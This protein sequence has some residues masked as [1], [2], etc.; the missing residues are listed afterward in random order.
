MQLLYMIA[1][2]TAPVPAGASLTAA[3][4]SKHAQ[5]HMGPL[6]ADAC[7]HAWNQYC[8]QYGCSR[9]GVDCT[10]Q[11]AHDNTPAW[12]T[13][14]HQD[15]RTRLT[16]CTFTFT[17]TSRT[18]R[19]KAATPVLAARAEQ[20][21]QSPLRAQSSELSEPQLAPG[22]SPCTLSLVQRLLQESEACPGQLVLST[23]LQEECISRQASKRLLPQNAA[24]APHQYY[25]SCLCC[26]L[27]MAHPY[28]A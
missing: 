7:M 3:T 5:G 24:S 2:W 8:R 4:S 10:A 28:P 14:L 18:L 11:C 21:S 15:P 25:L 1:L 9:A 22:L 6:L 13:W 27:S 16:A 23:C 20:H 17:C 26:S 12:H 19:A